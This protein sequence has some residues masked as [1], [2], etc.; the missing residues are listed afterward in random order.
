MA[1]LFLILLIMLNGVFALS[2]MAIVSSRKARMQ[3]MADEGSKGA[4]A[5]LKL[6][7]EPNR[8]LS[9][10]QIGITLI[11][12]LAGA[13][14]GAALSEP[15]RTFLIDNFDLT[16]RTAGTL[17]VGLIVALTT[18][19]SLVIGELVPKRVALSNPERI[20][21]RIAVPMTYLSRVTAP[22]VWF[23]SNSTMLV[24]SL[25]GV[26]ASDENAITE[27]EVL[28]MMR[29]GVESGMFAAD[30]H[31][32]VEGVM[33]LDEIRVGMLVTPRTE[34]AAL[35]LAD[36][37]DTIRTKISDRPFATY[38]VI[39]GSMDKIIGVV[40][41]RDLL[42]SLLNHK[43]INLENLMKEPVLIPESLTVADALEQFKRTG[44]HTAMVVGEYGGIEGLVRMHDVMEQIVGEL[45][46]GEMATHLPE[47]FQRDDGS[48]LLDGKYSMSK[49]VGIY[50]ALSIPD[51]EQGNYETL[52][53]FVMVRLGRVPHV[54]DKFKWEHLNFEVVDMDAM[55]VDRIM[56]SEAPVQQ[57]IPETENVPVIPQANAE[58]IENNGIDGSDSDDEPVTQPDTEEALSDTHTTPPD[59]S[60]DA[61]GETSKR[62]PIASIQ[63]KTD[64]IPQSDET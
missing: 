25:L 64:K 2:E 35:D 18:Y 50:P 52:A 1:L 23:L 32:M 59:A 15:L 8:F 4:A 33:R 47:A 57:V 58:L 44:M 42:V 46:E 13:F 30:E 48:W 11:G 17:S 38:P 51:N 19:L 56:V 31:E 49:L 55:R 41:S 53:G 6:M 14:G 54:G 9:T 3:A 62:E 20:A 28:A 60:N 21:R 63:I 40:R 61:I 45:D 7:A 27:M 10:V 5:A 43:D 26:K 22:L 39:D 29:E 37:R 36:D 24:T 16:L 34:I 12:I